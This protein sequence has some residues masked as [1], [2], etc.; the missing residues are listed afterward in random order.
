MNGCL[1]RLTVLLCLMLVAGSPRALEPEGESVPVLDGETAALM[2]QAMAVRDARALSG[3]EEAFR[4]GLPADF[5][6]SDERYLRLLAALEDLATDGLNPDDYGVARLRQWPEEA[7]VTRESMASRG[8]LLALLHLYRG[9]V[10]PVALDAHWNF[11]PGRPALDSLLQEARAAA[12][13]GEPAAAFNFA[14]PIRPEYNQLRTALARYRGIAHE[15]GWPQLPVGKSLKPG[16]S[17]PRVPVLRRRLQ[18][19]GLASHEV[20]ADPSLFDDELA[21][22]VMR[23]QREAYLAADGV[24]GPST[25]AALNAP[26]AER[27]DQ[28]RANLERMRWVHDPGTG[29]MVVVDIAGFR[30]AYLK[31][32]KAVWTSR[33]QVGRAYRSTPVFRSRVTHLTLNPAWTVPPTIMAKDVLPKI[34]KNRSYLQ[35][36]RLK[37]YTADGRPLAASAVNWWQ[38]GNIVLRQQAG[39]DGAL[40]QM[41]IRFPNAYAVYLHDTPHKELFD[42]SQRAFSSGCIRVENVHELAVLLLDDVVNWSRAGL[43]AA[44]AEGKTRQV[45]LDVPVPILLAYWTVDVAADG[46]VSFKTDIYERDKPLV[47]VLDRLVN[48]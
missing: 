23:F 19:A 1:G 18:I 44:I 30:I 45:N 16:Q 7:A 43:D 29:P 38:P 2:G 46:Y 39:E 3:F 41:A 25:R 11:A 5:W 20:P 4:K 17:D 12:E 36:N 40:G 15:G 10:D 24:V 33:V 32:G 28:L 6:D 26:V 27:I 48:L 34:R 31:E 21:R 37:V 47:T 8:Y 13:R 14:R 35:K 42:S 22:A 9:K